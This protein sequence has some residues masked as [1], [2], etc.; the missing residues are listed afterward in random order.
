MS[1]SNGADEYGKLS[2][3]DAGYGGSAY[4]FT[5]GNAEGGESLLAMRLR[6]LGVRKDD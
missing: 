1:M 6:S 3:G 4:T 2:K 5:N